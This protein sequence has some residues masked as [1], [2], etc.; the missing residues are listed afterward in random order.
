MGVW[1]ASCTDVFAVGM[2]GSI[3]HYN[4]SSWSAMTSNTP[5]PLYSVW[6][7]SDSDVF[8]VGG[9]AG[10]SVIMRYNG[11]TW[12]A[13]TA[14]FSSI[15]RGVWGTSG[16][17]VFAVG[18]GGTI[19]HYN[20]TAW[21]AMTSNTLENL[22]GV[23]GT[24]GSNVYAVGSGGTVVR[25]DGFVWTVV[26]NG[27]YNPLNAVWGSSANDI[28]AVVNSGQV[29]HSSNGINWTLMPGT[30]SGSLNGIWG[31]SATNVFVVNSN[32]SPYV[33]NGSTW[34]AMT[35][36]TSVALY[37]VGGI[38]GGDIYA[39]GLSG[40][41]LHYGSICRGNCASSATLNTT[42]GAVG[43]S[44]SSACVS[45]AALVPNSNPRCGAPSGYSF[46]YGMFSFDA[47]AIAPGQPGRITIR[48]PNPLPLT[49][50]YYNC[51]NGSL[52]DISSQ[53]TRSTE[54]IIMLTLTSGGVYI[55][56][57]AFAL[58]ATP[59][60]SSPWMPDTSKAAVNLANIAVK[61]ASLSATRVGPGELV[62]VTADVA[63]TGIGNGT[64]NIKVYVNGAEETSQGVSVI[65]G[66]S[67]PVT[68]TVSRNEPGAYTVYVGGTQAGSFTVDQFTP[69]T[70]LFISGALVF[71]ALV[72][73]MI[74]MTRRRARG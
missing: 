55:I 46:P 24:S 67:T 3:T 23:W 53:V 34:R 62:T 48:F 1:A 43:L 61:K 2:A 25:Y 69:T 49:T 22:N 57:P 8:A 37:G 15:L 44:S 66:T 56:G 40:T 71:F 63:N 12:S 4:G 21:S 45:N 30:P 27:I 32:G 33:Y 39:V 17:D 51:V 41:I 26:E 59:Q 20:G 18:Y 13:M 47:G 54:Y 74:Y 72:I 7:S 73:G 60:S 19:L 10:T 5:Y 11:S 9:T 64:S 58:N 38:N 68:F 52:V 31:S 35:C 14:P 6:G 36:D 16:S 70:V 29:I 42:L 50:K 28:F 65:S